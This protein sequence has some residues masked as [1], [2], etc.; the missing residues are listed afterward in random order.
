MQCL[1]KL[2]KVLFTPSKGLANFFLI[3]NLA[4]SF[5]SQAENNCG[6]A[7]SGGAVSAIEYEYKDPL[8]SFKMLVPAD[9]SVQEN[10]GGYAL[11]LEP[12]V[13]LVPTADNPLVANPTMTVSVSANPIP[14][15]EVELA[16][17]EKEIREKFVQTNGE[18]DLN[19]FSK[20]LMDNLPGG[21]RGLL[22]YYS[23]KK[24]GLDVV[25]AML[26]MSNKTH[27]YRVILTDYK[28]CFSLNL[29]RYFPIMSSLAIDGLPILRTSYLDFSLPILLIL[30]LLIGV[31]T[32]IR[33]VQLRRQ[34]ML[35]DGDLDLSSPKEWDDDPPEFE[36]MEK[37]EDTEFES[38]KFTEKTKIKLTSKKQTEYDVEDEYA[39]D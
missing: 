4:F 27:R 5:S 7:S 10:F 19:I 29:E 38:K 37:D 6:T 24:N 8:K 34:R 16:S 22:Y 21:K 35:L 26:I 12:K 30:A 33:L 9:W 1:K 39:A 13:K 14:I 36:G 15:D 17:F 18:S 3:C 32:I 23:Y 28:V 11:M 20:S 2:V 25:S 31:F